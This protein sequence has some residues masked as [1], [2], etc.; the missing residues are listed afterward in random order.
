[1][2]RMTLHYKMPNEWHNRCKCPYKL[3]KVQHRIQSD[4]VDINYC[5]LILGTL[6]NIP[7]RATLDTSSEFCAHTYILNLL[8]PVEF[9]LHWLFFGPLEAKTL[10]SRKFVVRSAGLFVNRKF[11]RLF[12]HV[13]LYHFESWYIHSA[14]CTIYRVGVSPESGHR[15]LLEVRSLGTGN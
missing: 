13:L 5:Q 14:G 6:V 10:G 15:D 3:R 1:M 12:L 11:F 2:T 4:F 9:G 8:T 7:I